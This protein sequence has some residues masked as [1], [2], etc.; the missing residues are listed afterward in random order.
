VNEKAPATTTRRVIY[1]GRV[2]GVGFRATARQMALGYQITG[3]VRNLAD[4]TV[5]LVAQGEPAEVGRYL[6][7]L[8]GRMS[9]LIAR[10]EE[11]DMPEN[12]T[13]KGFTIR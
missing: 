11:N 7:A 10:A 9:A 2:Q 8:A 4:G 1:H 5:E 6:A 13:L 3:F 12:P